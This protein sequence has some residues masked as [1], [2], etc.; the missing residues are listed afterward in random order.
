[1]T[2]LLKLGILDWA[3]TTVGFRLGH[4]PQ[5]R[6]DFIS[7]TFVPIHSVSSPGDQSNSAR[8]LG[9]SR[10]A[11]VASTFCATDFNGEQADEHPQSA[12]TKTGFL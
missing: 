10:V 8:C 5:I 11:F 1:M 7:F 9:P 12:D 3:A 4:G 2:L 6:R